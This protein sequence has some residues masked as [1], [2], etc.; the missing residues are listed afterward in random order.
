MS[1][2]LRSSMSPPSAKPAARLLALLLPFVA[3]PARAEPARPRPTFRLDYRLV[4]LE[5]LS[6]CPSERTVAALLNRLFRYEAIQPTAGPGLAIDI[7]SNAGQHLRY[8]LT[9]HVLREDGVPIYTHEHYSHDGTAMSC[10]R[11]ST[12]RRWS[13]RPW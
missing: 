12:R 8:E 11:A 7:I 10:F 6:Y 1:C 2:P 13:S 3:V 9:G 5:S 4:G